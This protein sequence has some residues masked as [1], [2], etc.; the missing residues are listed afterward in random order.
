[1]RHKIIFFVRHGQSQLNFSN[2]RQGADGPLSEAGKGQAAKA[3]ELLATQKIDAM[4]AS[5]YQRAKETADIIA[6]RLNKKI[7]LCDLLVERKNPSEIVGHSLEEKDVREIVEK[8]ER[9]YH[10][11]SLR[12]SDEENFIDLKVRAQKLTRFLESR[13][14]KR[15]LCVTHGVFLKMVASYML[16]GEKVTATDYVKLSQLN[17]LHNAGIVI[18]LYTKPLFKPGVWRILIWDNTLQRDVDWREADDILR[19]LGT[20][21]QDISDIF[22]VRYMEA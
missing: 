20:T 2:V 4:Y 15:I 17:P 18:C 11:D 5:P 16:L 9:S 13:W 6:A 19:S 10:D 22:G 8:F 14:S 1:M 12:I 21:Y 3:A 7:T